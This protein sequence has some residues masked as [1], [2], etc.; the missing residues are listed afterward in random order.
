MYIY[1]YTYICT[2]VHSYFDLTS[3]RLICWVY[4]Q[5]FALIAWRSDPVS[6]AMQLW[7]HL[8]VIDFDVVLLVKRR[9]APVESR[10]AGLRGGKPEEGT[11]SSPDENRPSNDQS[12][13]PDSGTD[14]PDSDSNAESE[15]QA[16]NGAMCTT[17][18]GGSVEDNEMQNCQGGYDPCPIDHTG[19]ET[20]TAPGHGYQRSFAV[21][22][23]PLHRASHANDNSCGPS[24]LT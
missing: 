3:F 16:H 5:N 20:H 7:H 8:G 19:W 9:P 4:L 23:E 17:W 6:A 18:P 2:Y 13:A 21:P 11:H 14:R 12:G 1:I 10:R 15:H 22:S 24:F